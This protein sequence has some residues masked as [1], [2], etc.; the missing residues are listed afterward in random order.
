ML[1]IFVTTALGTGRH[2]TRLKKE[3][4]EGRGGVVVVKEGWGCGGVAR[5]QRTR[6]AS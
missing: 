6:L 1:F 4:K 5:G 3:K 2:R